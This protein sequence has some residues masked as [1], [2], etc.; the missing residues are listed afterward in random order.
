MPFAAVA[1][2]VVAAG[3]S[4]YSSRQ[5]SNAV[6]DSS[7][8]SIAEQQR[9]FDLVRSDTAGQRQLG[10]N[11]ISTLSRL[12]GY[13]PQQAQVGAPGYST[14][15]S[16]AP[17]LSYN[18][19]SPTASRMVGRVLNRD[20][21]TIDNSTGQPVD[22]PPMAR[23]PGGPDMSV[24]FNSP[25]YAFNLAEGNKAIDRSAA[26]RGGLLS[27]AAVKEGTR[28]ASG[29]ASREYGAFVDRLMQQAGVGSTGIGASASAGANAANNI[30]ATA[31]N[32]GN[33]RASIYGNNAANINNAVQGGISN[34]MLQRYLGGASGGPA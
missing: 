22:Q 30:S 25:D 21:Q 5:Q 12:Y 19:M 23:G 24:F 14:P 28:Y 17:N 20:P 31:M 9:Q 3:A 27:G 13:G 11:A 10:N 32:A 34:Y 8:T 18:G 1:G 2:A 26:A 15:G 7:K 29:M 33:A 6:K 16:S 4:A